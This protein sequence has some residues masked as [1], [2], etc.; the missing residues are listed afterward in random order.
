MRQPS[1]HLL[2]DRLDLVSAVGTLRWREWGRYPEPED[3]AWWEEVARQE[4]GRSS[5]PV[6][7]VA[8]DEHDEV[9]G[10]VGLGEHDVEERRDVTPWVMGMIVRPDQ[11]GQ[12]IGRV[13]MSELEAWAAGHAVERAWVGTERAH[14]FYQRCGWQLVETY[15]H[16]HG[17]DVSVLTK[18]L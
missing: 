12:G 3:P 15:Q 2:A 5:V 1:V 9:V 7:F 11:R 13:L 14:G 18:R 17:T 16:L 10:A 4:A 8:L 6:T